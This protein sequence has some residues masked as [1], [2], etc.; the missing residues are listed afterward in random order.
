MVVHIRISCNVHRRIAVNSR[1]MRTMHN[2]QT[3]T[4][5]EK[6]G[7]ADCRPPTAE[8]RHNTFKWLTI[9]CFLC[10]PKRPVTRRTASHANRSKQI[11]Q[12]N[13]EMTK[14]SRRW[15]NVCMHI[16]HTHTHISAM[17]M[18]PSHGALRSNIMQNQDTNSTRHFMYVRCAR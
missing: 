16:P 18:H 9:L 8:C 15:A 11:A 6:K 7:G 4:N 5:E 12:K 2:E 3:Q 17:A 13:N 1:K 10:A 14:N